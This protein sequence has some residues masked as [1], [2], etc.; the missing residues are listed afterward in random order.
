MSEDVK[1]EQRSGD[2]FKD[3]GFSNT[4]AEQVLLKADL[5]VEIYKIIEAQ[6][7]TQAKAGKILS[8]DPSDI[9][10]LKKGDFNRFSVERLFTLLNRFNRNIEIRITPAEDRE[11]HQRVVA[12]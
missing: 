11:G 6:K 8:I 12:V 1:V 7:L 4:E 3:L 5:A 10:R 9:S 2:V